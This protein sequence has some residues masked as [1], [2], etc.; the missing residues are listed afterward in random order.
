MVKS[1]FSVPR[2]RNMS[3]STTDDDS[4]FV[5]QIELHETNLD[6]V[7]LMKRDFPFVHVSPS[8][9]RANVRVLNATRPFFLMRNNMALIVLYIY[10]YIVHV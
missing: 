3:I 8:R 4:A 9:E 6:R 10:H 7:K 1:E 5:E 2:G